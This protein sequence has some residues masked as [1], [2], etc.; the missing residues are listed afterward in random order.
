MLRDRGLDFRWSDQHADNIFAR[1][2]EDDGGS[3]SWVTLIE[4]FEHLLS[5]LEFFRAIVD[6]HQPEA[7]F[8]TTEVKTVRVPPQH[9]WYWGFE[10]GQ[11]VGFASQRSLEIIAQRIGYDLVSIGGHHL[12]SRN[13]HHT[14]AFRAACS[15]LRAPLAALGRRMMRSRTMADHILLTQL[16]RR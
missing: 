6:K 4:V 5:P 10:T 14:R 16:P 13:S 3:Y 12:L 8:F 11:H 9:W 2:F 1:G 15:R 7:L